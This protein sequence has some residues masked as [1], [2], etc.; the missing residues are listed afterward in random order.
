[1]S[2]ASQGTVPFPGNPQKEM[3]A[4]VPDPRG[5]SNQ[6]PTMRWGFQLFESLDILLVKRNGEV[7]LCQLMSLH[8]AQG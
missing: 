6:K 3:N 5:K 4:S 1:M 2:F 7:T 8:T